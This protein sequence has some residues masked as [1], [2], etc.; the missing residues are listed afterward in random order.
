[1]HCC[2]YWIRSVPTREIQIYLTCSYYCRIYILANS[3]VKQEREFK[4]VLHYDNLFSSIIQHKK[5]IAIAQFW[6][7]DCTK[8]W[9]YLDN[10]MHTV[11]CTASL[12]VK[13]KKM[14][15]LD[16]WRTN[17]FTSA[18]FTTHHYILPLFG[19]MYFTKSTSSLR[20]SHGVF[21]ALFVYGNHQQKKKRNLY[22]FQG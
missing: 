1:M 11:S 18:Y 8:Y 16:S 5:N 13:K 6:H 10:I 20:S 17:F 7:I 4:V 2:W 9:I 21:N 3:T 12:F 19:N 14:N 15:A 22:D